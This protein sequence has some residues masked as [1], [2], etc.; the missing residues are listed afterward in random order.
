MT[1]SRETTPGVS[2]QALYGPPDSWRHAFIDSL[3]WW[4]V[5]LAGCAVL[6]YGAGLS[7]WLAAVLVGGGIVCF[8]IARLEVRKRHRA[9]RIKEAS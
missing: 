4:L 3:A 6:M 7:W 5:A 8:S 2:L 9:K 1:D